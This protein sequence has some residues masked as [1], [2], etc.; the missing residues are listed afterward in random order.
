MIFYKTR[1]VQKGKELHDIEA[2]KKRLKEIHDHPKSAYHKALKENRI[3]V[4]Y[5]QNRA[6]RGKY[7]IIEFTEVEPPGSSVCGGCQ[8]RFFSLEEDYL[9]PKCRS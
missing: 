1:T 7:D 4:C 8:K 9:C 2:V 3:M 5:D 6:T